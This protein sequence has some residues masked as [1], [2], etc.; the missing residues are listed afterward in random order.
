MSSPSA[1]YIAPPPPP[2]PRL[3]R[4]VELDPDHPIAVRCHR[5]HEIHA[6][7]R[8]FDGRGHLTCQY[9]RARGHP[10]CNSVMIVSTGIRDDE[11]KRYRLE[12][13]V[14]YEELRVIERHHMSL[15]AMMAFL[16]VP[17][18][19]HLI[20]PEADRITR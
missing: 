19:A 12:I 16:G 8:T 9:G 20:N 2:G 17:W 13:H 10:G 14:E 5:G 4:E 15:T 11:G 1:T 6:N 3:W 18:P 7:A